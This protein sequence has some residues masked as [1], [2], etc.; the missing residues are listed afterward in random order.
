[1]LKQLLSG[2]VEFAIPAL[3]VALYVLITVGCLLFTKYRAGLLMSFLFTFYWVFILNR[4]KIKTF[5]GGENSV[6]MGLY[7]V[8]GAMVVGLSLWAFYMED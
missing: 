2:N 8:S 6:F 1:M 4:E 5:T 3:Q 7:F